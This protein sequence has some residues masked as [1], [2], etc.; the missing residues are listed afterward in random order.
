MP[1]RPRPL[2]APVARALRCRCAVCSSHWRCTR[3]VGV[4]GSA[5]RAA[6]PAR[7]PRPR[8]EHGRRGRRTAEA[9]TPRARCRRS[10]GSST[11]RSSSALLVY[12]LGRRSPS[13][14]PSRQHADPPGPGRPPPRCGP[15]PTAQLADDR[16]EAEG[17]AGGARRAARAGR[18]GRRGRAARIA[19]AAA[20]ERERLLEQT[21]REIDMQ[22]RA[23]A[24]RAGRARRAARR[25]RG[26]GRGSQRT[27]TPED[28][29]RLVDRYAAQLQG[30]AMTAARIG[31]P[32]RARAVR[33]RAAGTGRPRRAAARAERVRGAGRPAT[34]RCRAR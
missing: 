1:L 4:A 7:A 22:L 31:D 2:D 11:S 30:G 20:A 29:L 13:T 14:S 5:P 10:R 21:R 19:Q 17:A 33:R 8:S 28:Q 24:A 18:R 12:F 15:P 26:A 16:A 3:R 25:R 34:R 9:S 32:L 23:G 6:A 27:I